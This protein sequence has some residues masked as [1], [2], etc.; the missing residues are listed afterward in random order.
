MTLA[1]TERDE[2]IMLKQQMK[3]HIDVQACD[4]A[5]IK[6]TTIRIETKL[7]AKVDKDDMEKLNQ[8][9]IRKADK[10][11]VISVAKAL[12]DLNLSK[13]DHNAIVPIKEKLDTLENRIWVA[14]W[15]VILSL[16]GAIISYIFRK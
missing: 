3:D 11:E 6:A 10:D 12:A 8:S 7:D 2:I 4:M 16:I 13:A 15:G 1:T 14:I 9:M 5:E